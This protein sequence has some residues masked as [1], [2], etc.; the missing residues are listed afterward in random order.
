M[1][2]RKYRIRCSIEGPAFQPHFLTRAE[3]S[4]PPR[5]AEGLPTLTLEKLVP[6]GI[7]E[8][9]PSYGGGAGK[10]E[11]SPSCRNG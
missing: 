7:A 6:G 2:T 8:V 11:G 10:G 1:L 5:R 9:R 4:Y 3:Q